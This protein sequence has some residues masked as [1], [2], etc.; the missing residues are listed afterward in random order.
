[1][2]LR[3]I[4]PSFLAFAPL[5]LSGAGCMHETEFT[6]FDG[7]IRQDGYALF[8]IK[9]DRAQHDDVVVHVG[10]VD[11]GTRYVLLYSDRAPASSGWFQLDPSTRS[12]CG[13]SPGPHCDVGDGFG[14]MVDVVTVPEGKSDVVLRH[15]VCSCDGDPDERRN[16]E[17]SAYY[18]VMRVERTGKTQFV[19]VEVTAREVDGYAE[20]P[21]I[22]QLQ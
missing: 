17:W 1:M 14:F 15:G 7:E 19:K 22:H 18:A 12:R 11:P 13:G 10:G 8:E 16:R 5:A 2:D 3:R 20:T 6:H 9:N 4:A 21:T